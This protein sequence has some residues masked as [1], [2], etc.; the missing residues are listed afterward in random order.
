MPEDL[1]NKKKTLEAAKAR[2][3]EEFPHL[4]PY[5]FEPGQPGWVVMNINALWEVLEGHRHF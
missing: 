1:M 3:I 5:D 2:L 4:R